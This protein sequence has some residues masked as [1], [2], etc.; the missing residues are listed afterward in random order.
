M[1]PI[2]PRVTPLLNKSTLA[3]VVFVLSVA[4]SGCGGAAA[5][6]PGPQEFVFTSVAPIGGTGA[7]PTEL[8]E[9]S[10]DASGVIRSVAQVP[11]APAVLQTSLRADLLSRFVL[12]QAATNC[13]KISCDQLAMLAVIGAD[14][15]LTFRPA[16][17]FFATGPIT[18]T[19]PLG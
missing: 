9:F 16:P 4:L 7:K 11:F 13:W 14:R 6:A 12:V 15:Q 17:Q 10:V 19:D 5:S 18:K 2:G 1:M 8:A 3:C